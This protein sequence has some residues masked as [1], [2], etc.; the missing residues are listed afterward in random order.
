MSECTYCPVD[1]ADYGT[2]QLIP[3]QSY[4]LLFYRFRESSVARVV[5]QQR[6]TLLAKRL[7]LV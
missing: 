6:K 7:L 2:N 4:S 5:S 3:N 1:V